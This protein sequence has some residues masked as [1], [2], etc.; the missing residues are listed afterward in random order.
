M[1]C[2]CSVP[3]VPRVEEKCEKEA[4]RTPATAYGTPLTEV[5]ELLCRFSVYR[6]PCSCR[7]TRARPSATT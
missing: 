6:D 7:I 2:T 4:I 5:R 1:G 3:V